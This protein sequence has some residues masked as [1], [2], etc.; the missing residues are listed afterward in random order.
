MRRAT[1][2]RTS[3][4]SLILYVTRPLTLT[5]YI[6]PKNMCK[7]RLFGIRNKKVLFGNRK[8]V[9]RQTSRPLA[10]KSKQVGLRALRRSFA[11]VNFRERKVA[12]S[13]REVALPAGLFCNFLRYNS[14][15]EICVNS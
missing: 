4:L 3:S 7:T 9:R 5:K 15:N 13:R 1:C 11:R 10:S 8:R 6:V 12:R 14:T 2:S